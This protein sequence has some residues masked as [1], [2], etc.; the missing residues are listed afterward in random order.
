[1]FAK[2]ENGKNLFKHDKRIVDKLLFFV[3][4]NSK[5]IEPD[6]IKIRREYM[7]L[8]VRYY[9]CCKNNILKFG[10]TKYSLETHFPQLETKNSELTTIFTIFNNDFHYFK[11]IYFKKYT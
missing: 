8:Y 1:V 5:N 3:D 10:N 11:I 4:K 6:K 9:M 7:L 2:V